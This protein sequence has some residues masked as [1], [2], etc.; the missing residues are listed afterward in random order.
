M[1]KIYTTIITHKKL[2]KT[3]KWTTGKGEDITLKDLETDHLIN[4]T[5]Y[6][7]KKIKELREFNLPINSING[8]SLIDWN[9]IML[10]E[11]DHRK[12]L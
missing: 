9:V 5:L 1:K 3:L 10:N 6:I 7:C 11:L 12:K 4:I 8:K 2:R